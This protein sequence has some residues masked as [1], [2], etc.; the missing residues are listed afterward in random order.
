MPYLHSVDQL[1]GDLPCSIR[2]DEQGTHGF[3]ARYCGIEATCNE[4]NSVGEYV[5]RHPKLLEIILP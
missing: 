1:H 5:I 3:P 2:K 4:G